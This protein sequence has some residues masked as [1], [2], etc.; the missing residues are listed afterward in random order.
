MVYGSAPGLVGISLILALFPPLSFV[1]HRC[2][3]VHSYIVHRASC[4]IPKSN[5]CKALLR[6]GAAC[7]VLRVQVTY[8][9]SHSYIIHPY[10]SL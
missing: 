10:I 6:T 2:Y 3:I 7:C 5:L 9:V 4:I 8:A 1:V